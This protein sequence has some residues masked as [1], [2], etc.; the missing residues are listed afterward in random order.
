MGRINRRNMFKVLGIGVASAVAGH[1]YFNNESKEP[2]PV[3]EGKVLC[4]FHAHPTHKESVD[5]IVERLSSPGLVGLTV[6]DIDASGTAVLRYEQALDLLPKGSFYETDK[7][8][9]AKMGQGYFAR[10]QEIQVGK[11]HLLVLGWEGKDYFPNMENI[12][13]AVR[14]IH[15]KKGIAVL[16]HPFA[17]VIGQN[18][19]MPNSDE[20]RG[21][22]RH[23]YGCVDEVETKNA[24]CI[25]LVPGI[26]DM[27]PANHNAEQLRRDEFPHFNGMEASDCHRRWSQIKIVGNYIPQAVV[28]SGMDGIK[29]AIKARNFERLGDSGPYISRG[30]FTLGM[31][32]DIITSL[33]GI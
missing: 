33:F 2:A 7:G 17:L 20:E 27:Q 26:I 18:V 13:E 3:R 19:R 25:K 4:D 11:H 9:V 28:E 29:S 1:L 23:A 14:K 24:Y 21:E 22:I 8:R 31:G 12:D 10:T 32:R 16:N 15:E 6:K 5:T 30:S